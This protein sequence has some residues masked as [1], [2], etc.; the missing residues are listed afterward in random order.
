MADLLQCSVCQLKNPC[1]KRK[2]SPP[3]SLVQYE[4]A[5]GS[6]T[7]CQ[8]NG[9][10]PGAPTG[11]NTFGVRLPRPF[12]LCAAISF[13]ATGDSLKLALMTTRL[14]HSHL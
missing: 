2:D 9:G 14:V 8:D 7:A 6:D 3:V 1:M 13:S 10:K 11:V 5:L 4:S 12:T